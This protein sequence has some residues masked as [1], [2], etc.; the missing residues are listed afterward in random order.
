[1]R[2]RAKEK[3]GENAPTR[4][5]R[6]GG[7]SASTLPGEKE[8]ER[9]RER[10][11]EKESPALAPK[12]GGGGGE[13]QKEKRYIGLLSTRG[14]DAAGDGFALSLSHAPCS[15]F[16]APAMLWLSL[17]RRDGWQFWKENGKRGRDCDLG[18]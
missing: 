4:A 18:R 13:G 10:V 2:A 8:T 16:D 12:R 17:R 7:C 9:E 1:M 14:P 15:F 11:R 6:R 3:E 5:F